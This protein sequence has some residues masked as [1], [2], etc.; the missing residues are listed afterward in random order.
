MFDFTTFRCVS[1]FYSFSDDRKPVKVSECVH[2]MC[3]RCLPKLS[4]QFKCPIPDCDGEGEVDQTAEPVQML[5]ATFENACNF[6]KLLHCFKDNSKKIN[7]CINDGCP[8]R[9]E[10]S[11][12][13]CHLAIHGHCNKE[14]SYDFVRFLKSLKIDFQ[15]PLVEIN[16]LRSEL[17]ARKYELIGAQ[18]LEEWIREVVA[19][20]VTLNYEVF[21]EAPDDYALS[22][23]E[24]TLVNVKSVKLERVGQLFSQIFTFLLVKNMSEIHRLFEE[25]TAIVGHRV[26]IEK[27]LEP[28]V[29]ESHYNHTKIFGH[30][31]CCLCDESRA[32]HVALN[33]LNMAL[34]SRLDLDNLP[35]GKEATLAIVVKNTGKFEVEL[36]EVS[37]NANPPLNISFAHPENSGHKH[38]EAAAQLQREM[39]RM[40]DD[41]S[42]MRSE[43]DR[44]NRKVEENERALDLFKTERRVHATEDSTVR[45]EAKSVT[46]MRTVEADVQKS[47]ALPYNI[48]SQTEVTQY[49]QEAYGSQG[50]NWTESKTA[51]QRTATIQGT[52]SSDYQE[53][54]K[55]TQSISKREYHVSTSD[56]RSVG[57]GSVGQSSS[58]L[59]EIRSS[60]ASNRRSIGHPLDD[61][62]F[63]SQM[64][65][66]Y[67]FELF[68][69]SIKLKLVYSSSVNGSDAGSFHRHCDEKGPTLVV[70]RS[71]NNIAG[72]Y[73]DKSW[74]SENGAWKASNEAFL[75]SVTKRKKYPVK[76]DRYDAIYCDG[77]A[78]PSFGSGHD[79]CINAVLESNLNYSNAGKSYDFSGSPDPKKELFG[80]SN[81][82]V[83][84]YEVYTV[85]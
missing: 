30:V 69:R 38:C 73:T 49:G 41:F 19:K 27:I 11:C 58:K 55:V 24:E 59:Q 53:S 29:T 23:V 28:H 15:T 6:V 57:F 21:N 33:Q 75:F 22:V 50:R 52:A 56:Q 61:A 48:S 85:V 74:T 34:Q 64:D 77:T 37:G 44:L 2:F 79:L 20:L 47:S 13:I 9:R 43:I 84:E 70:I 5:L 7:I 45:R 60:D 71:G 62:R 1:C 81:F 32:T 8:I 36:T 26:G 14:N 67:L 82:V 54:R 65:Q 51:T 39:A 18:E 63:L 35:F 42:F 76:P 83:N 4:G 78:G 40:R 66:A 3:E 72:G 68:D 10:F 17:Q 25:V 80:D 46:K 12:I 16:R 31:F